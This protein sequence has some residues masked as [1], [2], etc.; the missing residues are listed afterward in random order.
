MW[1]GDF[2]DRA[3][4]AL[5]TAVVSLYIHSHSVILPEFFYVFRSTLAITSSTAT[6]HGSTG[7]TGGLLGY[8][9]ENYKNVAIR[10]AVGFGSNWRVLFFSEI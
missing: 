3:N 5:A 7:I 10:R 8:L 2:M 6:L 1:P 9:W 4:A